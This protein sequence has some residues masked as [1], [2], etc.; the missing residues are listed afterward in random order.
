L[1]S[2]SLIAQLF[3]IVYSNV[4]CYSAIRLPSRKCGINSVS[5]SVLEWCRMVT[6]Q[7]DAEPATSSLVSAALLQNQ[8]FIKHSVKYL[9]DQGLWPP[10][11][12]PLLV[13]NCCCCCY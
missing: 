11:L 3:H 2:L 9:I 13:M 8:T 7:Q 5:V 4:I 10:R 6:W 1:F 12:W